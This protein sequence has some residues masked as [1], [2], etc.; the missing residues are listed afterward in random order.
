MAQD[1]NGPWWIA[2]A[3]SF[4]SIAGGV[5]VVW[6]ALIER[7]DKQHTEEL[8]REQMLM[9]DLDLQRAAASKEASDVFE[10]V[11]SELARRDA[12]AMRRDERI[13]A[14]EKEIDRWVTVA[15]GWQ[16]RCF[17]LNHALNNTRQEINWLR[18][19]LGEVEKTWDDGELP[20][21]LEKPDA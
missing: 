6:K 13:D 3:A 16:T 21:Q 20:T 7:K 4:P 9:R 10:R 1:S 2:A 11:K 19:K 17:T 15:R 8:T 18:R 5:W 14:L 12:E